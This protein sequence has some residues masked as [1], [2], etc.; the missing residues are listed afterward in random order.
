MVTSLLIGYALNK[1]GTEGYIFPFLI[2]SF[3]YLIGIAIVHR[4][5]P[6]MK[7]VTF[8]PE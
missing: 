4:L 5:S 6:S 3:G 7:P 2:A 1:T 8:K